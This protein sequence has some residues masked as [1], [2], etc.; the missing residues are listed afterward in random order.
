MFPEN[1]LLVRLISN[2][3]DYQQVDELL[4]LLG[5]ADSALEAPSR[6]VEAVAPVC[7]LRN[8]VRHG[9]GAF[10]AQAGLFR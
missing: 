5:V 7:R 4:S 9:F 1:A 2:S 10:R 3:R 6:S 8:I